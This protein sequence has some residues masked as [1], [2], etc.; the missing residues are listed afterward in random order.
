MSSKYRALAFLMST[1][2]ETILI[3]L[4]VWFASNWLDENYPIDMAWAGPLSALGLLAIV[5]VWWRLFSHLLKEYK[6]DQMK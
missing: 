2:I 3:V 4:G 5:R 6:K 1:N